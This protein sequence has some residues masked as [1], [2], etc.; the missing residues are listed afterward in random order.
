MKRKAGS[1]LLFCVMSALLLSGCTVTASPTTSV[2]VLDSTVHSEHETEETSCPI[3][4]VS[5]APFSSQAEPSIATPAPS[6]F[7]LTDNT[8]IDG[9]EYIDLSF[10]TEEQQQLYTA[11]Y[12]MSFGLY[13]G[14]GALMNLWEYKPVIDSEGHRELWYDV[15]YN[16][17]SSQIHEIFT[18]NALSTTDYAVTFI[19]YDCGLAVDTRITDN[20]VNG[21]TR[22]VLEVYPD[23]YRP[24][25]ST[26]DKVTFTLISH[27]DRNWNTGNDIGVFATEYPIC[28]VNTVSWKRIDEFHTTMY[29]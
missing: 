11:A 26:E 8:S 12:E 20:L 9:Q 4:P 17:F 14:D 19:N 18:D 27:Y 10:L 13:G 5:P 2:T 24:I 21:T 22:Q 29:G 7:P 15:P 28:M 1:I 23:T 16:V 3:N 25:G 6:V